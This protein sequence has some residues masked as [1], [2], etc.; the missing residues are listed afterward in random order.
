MTTGSTVSGVDVNATG[1][2]A[3]GAT[4]PVLQNNTDI[5]GRLVGTTVNVP[6]TFPV[7]STPANAVLVDTSAALITSEAPVLRNQTDIFGRLV[8][9]TV[10]P[11]ATVVSQTA[12]GAGTPV[13][14]VADGSTI[15][16]QAN[17]G[18][19]PVVLTVQGTVQSE[20]DRQVILNRFQGVSG[21]TVVDQLRLTTPTPT[22]QS[23]ATINEAAGANPTFVSPVSPTL[24]NP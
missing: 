21:V 17:S 16:N 2:N 1:V 10:V 22:V 23:G 5:F 14:S 13:V 11:G 15:V 24:I 6:S 3:T 4:T 18:S 20:A 8:G 12:I 9:T 7:E 19:T